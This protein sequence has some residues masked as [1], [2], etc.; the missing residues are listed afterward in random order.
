VSIIRGY[1]GPNTLL[2]D[3]DTFLL[4]A[5]QSFPESQARNPKLIRQLA[6][7]RELISGAVN[8]RLDQT[9]EVLLRLLGEWD[10][11]RFGHLQI[12]SHQDIYLLDI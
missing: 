8:S 5:Q 12:I 1:K 9:K 6:L 10:P 7:W 4:E 3:D 2:E 11:L